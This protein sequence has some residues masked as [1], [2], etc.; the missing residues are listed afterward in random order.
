MKNFLTQEECE[1]GLTFIGD[2]LKKD[3]S[4]DG[5]AIFTRMNELASAGSYLSE[6]VASTVLL[7]GDGKDPY[8]K[9]LW[10]LASKYYTTLNQNIS[11]YQSILNLLKQDIYNSKLQ[12]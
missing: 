4:I 9:A 1:K 6:I 11:A 7:E 12:K 3:V 2:L 8:T 10:T 5:E